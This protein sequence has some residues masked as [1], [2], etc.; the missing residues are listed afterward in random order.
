M[1]TLEQTRAAWEAQA[2]AYDR[3]MTPLAAEAARRALSL[4]G[5][6]NGTRLIDIASGGGALSLPAA[7]LGAEVLAVDYSRAMVEL[8]TAKARERNLSN[9]EVR[10]MDGTALEIPDASFDVACSELGI[11]LFPDR[12]RGMR[13]MARVLEDGG[14]GVMIVLGPPERVQVISLFFDALTATVPGFELPPNSPLFCLQEPEV[15]AAEMRAAGFVA[16]EVHRFETALRTASGDDLWRTVMAGAPAITGLMR[17]VPEAQQVQVRAALNN[18]VRSR[19]EHGAPAALPVAFNI[20]I[21]TRAGEGKV[22]SGMR[23]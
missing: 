10:V 23:E 20:A 4:A 22:S 17:S 1:T 15:L 19:S 11:M 8:L 18:L 13:E 7:D 12:A 9:L 14:K 6:G 16:I 2:E 5:V 3:V 21:G